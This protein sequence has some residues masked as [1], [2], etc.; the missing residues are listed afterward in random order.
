VGFKN[1]P[2]VLSGANITD[3]LS[4]DLAI[5]GEVGLEFVFNVG[6]GHE[7]RWETTVLPHGRLLVSLSS[8]VLPEGSKESFVRLLEFA[9]EELGCREVYVEF[10][11]DSADRPHLI[12]TFM[13]FGFAVLAPD[14]TPFAVDPKSITMV[15]FVE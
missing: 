10:A 15:Y 5:V 8:T 2:P 3:L 12:R 9:E 4:H 7:V 6:D 11:K 14:T 13:F 1:E